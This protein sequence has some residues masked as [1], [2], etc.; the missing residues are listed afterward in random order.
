MKLFSLVA[1]AM[2]LAGCG[3]GRSAQSESLRQATEQAQAMS[4]RVSLSAEGQEVRELL[5]SLARRGRLSITMTP[6]AQGRVQV[7]TH[8]VPLR[9]VFVVLLQSHHLVY[10]TTGNV[11]NIMTESEYVERHGDTAAP[12]LPGASPPGEQPPSERRVSIEANQ[13]DIVA[14]IR[15]LADNGDLDVVID[16]DVVGQVTLRWDNVPAREA[17][18]SLMQT[19]ALAYTRR[20]SIYHIMT[21]GAYQT[22]YGKPFAPEPLVQAGSSTQG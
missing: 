12:A 13:R 19:N 4:Q 6:T 9:D 5:T 10:D 18:A 1:V 20:G 11:Y 3:T 2:S 16:P 8:D 21:G 17:L 7:L 22:R 14:V 15:Q